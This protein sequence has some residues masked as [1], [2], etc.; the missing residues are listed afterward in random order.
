M[1]SARR[2]H[3]LK[4]RLELRQLDVD[5]ADLAIEERAREP[6]RLEEGDHE[7]RPIA[8]ANHSRGHCPAR[9]RV[10]EVAIGNA[11]ASAGAHP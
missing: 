11:M 7:L 3:Y 8:I 10:D 6:R 9:L 5:Q 2:R 1:I 4:Q